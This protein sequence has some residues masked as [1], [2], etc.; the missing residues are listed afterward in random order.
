[1]CLRALEASLLNDLTLKGVPAITKCT[2]RKLQASEVTEVNYNAET[3]AP[4][5]GGE[6]N[7]TSGFLVETDG[8]ALK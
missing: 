3:G 5:G 4:E 7:Q 2:R 8:V 1:M 6:A